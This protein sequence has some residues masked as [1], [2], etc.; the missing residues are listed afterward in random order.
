ML[1]F[2]YVSVHHS[3]PHFLVTSKVF[4]DA[5]PTSMAGC[6]A[7]GFGGIGAKV[8]RKLQDEE[9]WP[10]G[11]IVKDFIRS[12]V[13]MNPPAL[14]MDAA[15]PACLT[16]HASSSCA[17]LSHVTLHSWV[18]RRGP[19][20]VHRNGESGYSMYGTPSRTVVTGSLAFGTMLDGSITPVP[21]VCL[22]QTVLP[23]SPK[24]GC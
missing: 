3:R 18:Q 12:W 9:G 10:Q 13:C 24:T 2:K 17:W 7:T 4:V 19:V 21:P 22:G 11:I 8:S 1:L 23:C 15:V 5:K 14:S 6:R 16:D 20:H